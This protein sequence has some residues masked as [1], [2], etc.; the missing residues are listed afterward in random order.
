MA[1]E[2][3]RTRSSRT[4]AGIFVLLGL[5]P[6]A[7][8][9]YSSLTISDGAVRTE[10]QA[11]VRTT[12]D[13]SAVFVNEQLGGLTDA[14]D[15]YSRR[16]DLIAAL[17]DDTGAGYKAPVLTAYLEHLSQVRTGVTGAFL[18]S[19][20]GHMMLAVP[21]QQRYE[22]LSGID[23]FVM[24]RAS[25]RPYVSQA[26][27]SK[28]FHAGIIG[29]PRVVA[30]AAPIFSNGQPTGQL[31]GVVIVA[32][33]L[34]AIQSFV[35]RAANAQ[36]ITLSVT[37]QKGGLLAAPGIQPY[38][39]ESRA[40]DP[41]VRAALKAESGVREVNRRA[42]RM[43]AAYA[44][45]APIGWT[46][47]AEVP[48]TIAFARVVQLRKT[49]LTIATLLGA[50]MVVGLFRGI[51]MHRRMRQLNHAL[52]SAARTDPLTGLGNRLRL[53]ED[54]GQLVGRATRYGHSY[55]IL[56]FDV[57]HFK[58]LNDTFGHLAGDAALRQVA[59]ALLTNCRNGDAFYR[60]GG[61]EFLGVLPEQ[62]RCD[63]SAAA[64][65]IRRLI[66]DLSI[67]QVDGRVVTVSVGVAC[68]QVGQESAVEE[69]LRL[70]D[71]ALYAAK[72]AGRNRVEYVQAPLTATPA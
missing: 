63:A 9:T 29:A 49:V 43:L 16:A 30:V 44:P 20:T 6:L 50:A 38:G 58:K 27:V 66:E 62:E 48:T 45:V 46:V 14:V 31:I 59:N 13:V 65:R 4:V 36:G 37:D 3:V 17:G 25:R 68:V 42:G 61:E 8:L 10:A 67:P 41:L 12:A 40:T 51:A 52:A 55:S 33:S 54:L 56:L 19:P 39:L 28:A 32:Y 34:D 11:R 24:V 18:I 57:D 70:A 15:S 71:A 21:R 35:T 53:Q 69:T 5:L 64:E 72:A 47:T 22:D 1:I 60:Y 2:E 23:W 7:L 26:Y